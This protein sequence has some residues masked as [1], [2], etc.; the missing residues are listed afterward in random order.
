MKSGV[1]NMSI[2]TVVHGG[3][4]SLADTLAQSGT[5]VTVDL[6]APHAA[7]LVASKLECGLRV[8]VAVP[9][10]GFEEAAAHVA[11]ILGADAARDAC[12]L[13]AES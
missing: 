2:L 10:T 3:A 4:E 5:D 8:A 9:A 7:A 13:T 11:T 1:A 6:G 12:Y